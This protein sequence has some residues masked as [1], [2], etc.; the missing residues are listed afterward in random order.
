MFY[1]YLFE[2]V[3]FALNRFERCRRRGH[4]FKPRPRPIHTSARQVLTFDHVEPTF[5]TQSISIQ[6]ITWMLIIIF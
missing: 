3:I 4:C 2:I 1:E 6:I 5:K